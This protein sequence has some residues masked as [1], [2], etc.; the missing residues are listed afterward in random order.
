MNANEKPHQ[1]RPVDYRAAAELL[2]RALTHIQLDV[3]AMPR[4]HATDAINERIR[5]ALKAYRK[6]TK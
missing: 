4:T 3:A 5:L 1:Q 6:A 2:L